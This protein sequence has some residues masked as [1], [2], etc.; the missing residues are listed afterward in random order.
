MRIKVD[1]LSD[2][3]IAAFLDEHIEEMK[4]V[5]PP[6]SKHA[7]DIEG[8]RKP[9]ITFWAA[10]QDERIVACGA[11]KE[12][13]STHAEVKSMRVSAAHR[14]KQLASN[15]LQHMLA[16]AKIRGYQKLSLETGSMAFF[17]PAHKL[18]A[19][20]GFK[21]CAPFGS[22]KE[23]PYSVFMSLSL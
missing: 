21:K 7:L 20:F 4:S 2:P 17:E 8:L 13:S 16:E 18:Y 19:K 11:L 10:W 12:L 5:S 22:Y 14:G 6:E 15:M 1:D 9:D 23:D 3:R